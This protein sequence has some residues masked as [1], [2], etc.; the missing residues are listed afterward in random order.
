MFNSIKNKIYLLVIIILVLFIIVTTIITISYIDK[1]TKKITARSSFIVL[2]LIKEHLSADLQSAVTSK[3]KAK[4]II[5]KVSAY[6]DFLFVLNK[7]GVVVS[8]PQNI[9][10]ANLQETQPGKSITKQLISQANEHPMGS[11]INEKIM[12]FDKLENWDFKI[13]KVPS[14]EWYIV[15]VTQAA[16]V[17]APRNQLIIDLMSINA[18]ILI[19]GLMMSI[20]LIR[21]LT[22]PLRHL[23]SYAHDLPSKNFSLSAN[24]KL[25]IKKLIKGNDEVASLAKAFLHMAESLQVYIDDLTSTTAAKER[26]ESELNVA[27]KIQLALLPD[28]LKNDPR[29]SNFD[30]YAYLQPARQVGGDLFDYFFIDNSHIYFFV[31]DVSDKGIPSSIF[32]A[33]TC[34]L[35]NAKIKDGLTPGEALTATNKDLLDKNKHNM[36]ATLFVGILNIDTGEIKYANAG[37]NDPLLL[38]QN[39][40]PKF[41]SCARKPVVGIIKDVIYETNSVILSANDA[42]FVYTD[43]VTEQ[44]NKKKQLFSEEGLINFMKTNSLISSSKELAHNLMNYLKKYAQG[45]PQSD[46]MTILSLR[47]KGKSGDNF[48]WL[49]LPAQIDSIEKIH[50]FILE[51]TKENTCIQKIIHDV[52]LATEEAIINIIKHAYPKNQGGEITFG[53]QNDENNECTILIM[54]KGKPFDP[55]KLGP[56]KIGPKLEETSI[57]GLGCH[58]MKQLTN[59][60]HYTFE[61]GE[62]I[63][64]LKFFCNP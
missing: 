47:F 34:T 17:D 9:N 43:G 5:D 54:D 48:N 63:L 51:Q 59:E 20:I 49:K 27:R 23:T 6:N 57:G 50:T 14:S 28:G 35:L 56:P 16:K 13:A 55:T 7:E 4:T 42:L 11:S 30:L 52:V 64:T 19:L 53:I 29:C 45:K 60:L 62:N 32:M 8:K 25:Q 26:I 38:R 61:N 46:D 3:V 37:H 22:N 18:I 1:G 40:P 21:R 36:F 12:L 24:T 33:V 58:L 44:I 2:N 39:K 10:L 31:G 15:R 41:L